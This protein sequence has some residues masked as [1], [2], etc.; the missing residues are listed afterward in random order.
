MAR[1]EEELGL[2]E[3]VAQ[4]Y[5]SESKY[6]FESANRMVELGRSCVHPAHRQGGGEV[7]GP[8]HPGRSGQG[9]GPLAHHRHR[10]A[11]G[12]EQPQ[13]PMAKERPITIPPPQ[14]QGEQSGDESGNPQADPDPDGDP[15]GLRPQGGRGDRTR[16]RR[17]AR[18]RRT[19]APGPTR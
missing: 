9:A 18:V 13:G 14:G 16:P 1:A 4:Q 6:K 19:A 10:A 3:E 12:P 2:F 11:Q 17:G 5:P 15:A 8:D 7:L